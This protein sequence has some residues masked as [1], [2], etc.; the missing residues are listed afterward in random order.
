MEQKK[1]TVW[2]IA[3]QW[4]DERR[5]QVAPS[6]AI[7]YTQLME[8][9]IKPYFLSITC[10][11]IEE[12]TLNNFYHKI[13]TDSGQKHLSLN[14]MRIIFMIMNHTLEYG[15]MKRY[16]DQKF[17]IKPCLGKK[18]PVVHVFTKEEQIKIERYI[19]SHPNVYSLAILL[20]LY[21]G[22]R[23]RELCALKWEDIDFEN[24]FL[25]V[26]KSVQRLK[27]FS[28]SGSGKTALIVSAPKTSASCRIIPLAK[29]VIEYMKKQYDFSK[30]NY[31]IFSNR[32]D[33]PL[34]PRTLQYAYRKILK[35][36]NVSYLN[37]HCL[38]HT[39]ATRCVT[40]GWDMKTL[41][42][43]LGHAQIKIT[44]EYYF[45]SSLEY[46]KAQMNKLFWMS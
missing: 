14:N 39:F 36:C 23:I 9:Y 18:K 35:Q 27:N 33:Q 11:E 29:F 19:L 17:Y 28:D 15:Y 22:I 4:I 12:K 43:I 13:Y 46:K 21:S 20:A 42:E 44:M 5:K 3:C 31:Y 2:E 7:K 32:Q 34:D 25:Q 41:S 24:G 37:F 45:H 10:D 6:T 40:I 30:K 8:H 16:L 38:R 26:T 1:T